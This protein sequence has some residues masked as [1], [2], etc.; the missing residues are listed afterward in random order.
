MINFDNKYFSVKFENNLSVS[1]F[2]TYDP[3]VDDKFTV[4]K[5]YISVFQITPAIYVNF[6]NDTKFLIESPSIIGI[7]LIIVG[8]ATDFDDC[9]DKIS[10]LL[11][12]LSR[13][14]KS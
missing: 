8:E 2:D 12:E 13:P 5:I 7:I 11:H 3:D 1:I 4:H 14:K 6:A 9:Q 10:S